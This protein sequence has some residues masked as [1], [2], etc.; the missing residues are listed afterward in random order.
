MLGHSSTELHLPSVEDFPREY[1]L[2]SPT[3][4]G[5]LACAWALAKH[6]ASEKTGVERQVV[7]SGKGCSL[8][9]VIPPTEIRVEL[10]E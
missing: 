2:P 3:V 8:F 9:Q 4:L 1:K 10:R 7:P 6:V 5:F